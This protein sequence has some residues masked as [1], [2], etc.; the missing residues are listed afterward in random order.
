VQ[1][2][3]WI[4]ALAGFAFAFLL[5]TFVEYAA[6]RLMH[7][8]KSLGGRH[9]THHQDGSGQG[10]WGE[11]VDYVIPTSPISIISL[12]IGYFAGFIAVGIGVAVGQILY[13]MLA[14]Y[15]H[16]IQH[17]RPELVF[18]LRRPVHHLHHEHKMWKNNFGIT[19]DFWDRIFGTYKVVEW[20]P[21]KR[22]FEHSLLSFLRIKWF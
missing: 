5:G 13:A 7:A 9:V 2:I 6:H 4:Q 18:W 14:A 10:W 15:A 3:H 20:N 8:R 22:P 1:L 17:E 11:F 19:V 12:T 21:E 16:Q